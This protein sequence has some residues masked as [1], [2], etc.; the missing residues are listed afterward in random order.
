MPV[1][2]VHAHC[3]PQ[4][5]RDWLESHH[6]AVG[7]GLEDTARGRGAVFGDRHTGAMPPDA[8]PLDRRMQE[9]D[10]MGID[11]QVLAGWIDLTGYELEAGQAAT[12]SQAHNDLLAEEAAAAGRFPALGTVPLQHPD[13]AIAELARCM[14]DLGMVGV[15]IA[16]TVRGRALDQAGLEGFWEAAEATGAFVL[17]HPMRPLPGIDLDRYFLS[18]AVGRPA[19]TTIALA[20]LIMAGVFDRY[21]ALRLCAVHGGGFA[22]FQ[23]GRL[24]RAAEVRPLEHITQRPS[25]YLRQ[26]YVDSVVHNPI[27]L[28][29]LVRVFG[30]DHVL[31]GTDYPFPMGDLDP[32]AF[33]ASVETLTPDQRSAIAGGNAARL[34]GLD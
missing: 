27:A 15:E 10:R 18:N 21:P 24:D 7:V 3:I 2:D 13:G 28:D 22:P 19:E 5:F 9:L 34:F 11:V 25:D 26:I 8:T 31:L 14:D 23:M 30:A 12:Y 17:L 29:Y 16:T 1:V 6:A 20:G 32:Q 4:A 33:L